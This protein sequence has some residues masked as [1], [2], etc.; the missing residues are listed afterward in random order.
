MEKKMEIERQPVETVADLR[1]LDH[2]EV[3]EGYR[4]G[5][6]DFPCGQNR[7]RSYWHGWQNGMR[8]KGRLP[9]T[10]E[11]QRLAHEFVAKGASDA[12]P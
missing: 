12:Q 7:S 11:S 8:D 4:D 1:T 10:Y 3:L 9:S 6:D 5:F 2:T